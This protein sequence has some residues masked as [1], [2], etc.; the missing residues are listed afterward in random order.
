MRPV[1]KLTDVSRE[2][3][4]GDVTTVALDGVN[5]E[6]AEGEFVAIVVLS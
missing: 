1:I 6:I 2:Y 3:R 4:I 5:L